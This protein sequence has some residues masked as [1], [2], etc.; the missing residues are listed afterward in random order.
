MDPRVYKETKQGT[1]SLQWVSAAVQYGTNLKNVGGRMHGCRDRTTTA[2]I[3]P[4]VSAGAPML[5]L[6]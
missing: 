1:Y 4:C 6:T 5:L 2:G 3:R